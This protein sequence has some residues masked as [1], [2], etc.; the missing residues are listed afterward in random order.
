MPT[1]SSRKGFATVRTITLS[2]ALCG[3]SLFELAARG[4][5]I[6]ELRLP[7]WILMGCVILLGLGRI[8]LREYYLLAISAVVTVVVLQ[9]VPQPLTEIAPS[10]DQAA[11]LMAFIILLSALNEV[12]ATSP[13]VAEC[14]AFLTRQ[15]PARRYYSISGGTALMSVV[16]NLSILSLLVPLI[17]NGIRRADRA[18]GLDAIREQRQISAL[19]RGFAWSVIW[20]PTAVAPL[21]LYD[22]LPEADRLRW[23]LTGLVLFA[24]I[25]VVGALEDAYRFRKYRARF[26][27]DVPP[28]PRTAALRLAATAGWLFCLAFLSMSLSGES[29]VFGLMM[30]CPLMLLGWLAVQH[31]YPRAFD[32]KSY[33]LALSRVLIGGIDKSV[34]IAVTLACSG[35]I[36]RA[37]AGLVPVED[38]ATFLNLDDVPEFVLLAAIPPVLSCLS[39]LAMSPIMLAVF[40]GTLFASLPFLPADPTLLALAISCGWSLSMTCSPFSGPTILIARAGRIPM[41]TLTFRWNLGFTLICAVLLVPAFW[42]LT[43]G[44]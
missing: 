16:F 43:G 42:L 10:L 18:D 27:A 34:P 37:A 29:F 28:F 39:M 12:A 7:T 26:R 21:V 15:P 23:I 24:A 17:Q 33:R 8:G 3:I 35:Y 44:R 32:R 36:G 2:A 9:T 11:F 5:G 25:L 4:T 41:A 19:L 6:G 38:I 40:F 14:G 31:G 20:S 1:N 22:L 13:S 30:A